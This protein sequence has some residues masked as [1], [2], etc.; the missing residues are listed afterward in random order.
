MGWGGKA[1]CEHTRT[2]I[3]TNFV[4]VSQKL[5]LYPK[6]VNVFNFHVSDTPIAWQRRARTTKQ[7]S[8]PIPGRRARPSEQNIFSNTPIVGRQ[9]RRQ[10]ILDCRPKIKISGGQSRTRYLP[11]ISY[12]GLVTKTLLAWQTSTPNTIMKNAFNTPSGRAV[13]VKNVASPREPPS[14]RS[15]KKRV[16]IR[17]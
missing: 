13:P 11:G 3:N 14:C 12:P 17:L 9:A 4:N 15:P 10:K 2:S 8:T 7:C 1:L 5:K 16:R 6:K